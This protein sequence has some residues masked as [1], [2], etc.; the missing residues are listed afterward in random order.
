MINSLDGKQG[1][2]EQTELPSTVDVAYADAR[3]TAS[4]SHP[5]VIYESLARNDFSSDRTKVENAKDP[6][7]L[8]GA[9]RIVDTAADIESVWQEIIASSPDLVKIYLMCSDEHEECKERTETCGDRGLKPELVPLLMEKARESNL[10]V[11]A[12]VESAYDFDVAV[13]AGV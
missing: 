11:A 12:H 7:A 1:L 10:R 8:G 3:I 6:K 2:R 4:Y 5:I 13:D 9:Y